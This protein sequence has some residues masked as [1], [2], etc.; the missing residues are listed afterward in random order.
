MSILLSTAY[1]APIE[2]YYHIAKFSEGFIEKYENYIK[3]T[4]RNRCLIYSANGMQRLSIPVIKVDGNHTCIKDI[5]ISY[6]ENWQKIHWK[7]IESAY[8][9]SPFFLYY[10]DDIK[11]FHFKKYKFLIDFNQDI[12]NV[13]LKLI[14]IKTIVKYTSAYQK[15]SSGIP[16]LRNKIKPGKKIYDNNK[17]NI[18]PHY[19]QV[20]E[21]K[22]GFIPNLS[23]IDLLFNEGPNTKEYLQGLVFDKRE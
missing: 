22:Y 8:N 18:I 20:F 12:L 3:Q 6:F 10:Q 15:E 11:P 4:Y 19:T 9:S 1:L 16:D 5:Q 21:A 7:S 13:I 14:G 17:L 23:I 2:Y